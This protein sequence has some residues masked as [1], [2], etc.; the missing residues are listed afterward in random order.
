M[1]P[2]PS[3][4][5]PFADLGECS[6]SAWLQKPVKHR[7]YSQGN[8]FLVLLQAALGRYRAAGLGP[9]EVP[10]SF[11]AALSIPSFPLFPDAALSWLLSGSFPPY[12]L[13]SLTPH[14]LAFLWRGLPTPTVSHFVTWLV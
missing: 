10:A 6:R 9:P 1:I 7:Q 13:N 4:G 8:R 12:C 2:L 11:L 3:L 5:Y 14:Q